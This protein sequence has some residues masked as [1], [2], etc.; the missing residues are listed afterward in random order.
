V[1]K[2]NPERAVEIPEQN[3]L[4]QNFTAD[5]MAQRLGN[6]EFAPSECIASLGLQAE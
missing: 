2:L 4:V 3:I 1:L 6:S 5:F